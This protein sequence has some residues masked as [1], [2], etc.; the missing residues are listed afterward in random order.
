MSEEDNPLILPSYNLERNAGGPIAVVNMLKKKENSEKHFNFIESEKPDYSKTGLSKIKELIEHQ[1]L[2]ETSGRFLSPKL[3]KNS[4][5]T[6]IN[7]KI[8]AKSFVSRNID[9]IESS[10]KIICMKVFVA[11][12]I[13]NRFPKKSVAIVYQGQG[14]RY[15]EHID[16]EGAT[17]NKLAKEISDNIERNVY[18]KSEKVIFPSEGSVAALKDTNT[19]LF[20]ML[21][22]RDYKIINNSIDIDKL[23]KDKFP[24]SEKIK[25]ETTTFATISTCNKAKGVDR[26]PEKLEELKEEGIEFQWILVSKGTENQEKDL[27]DKINDSN[28]SENTIWFNKWFEREEILGL[29]EKS[30]FYIMDHRYSIFDL[31]TI[32]AMAMENIPILSNIPG[33]R[34]FNKKENVIFTEN[35][36]D[37]INIFKDTEPQRMLKEK[38]KNLAFDL[39][40]EERLF[41]DYKQI[42]KEL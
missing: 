28:I 2:L 4:L 9:E 18:Q 16:R 26:I 27:R 24:E 13:I 38:N 3:P 10:E 37:N 35:I 23:H 15:N 19:S 6:V 34:E 31:T 33:N 21:E 32:E 42:V 5:K 39:F 12:E 11:N 29:L 30:D 7:E 17:P 22:R 40:N 14:S 1:G 25:E 20:P 41:E 36:E 8:G